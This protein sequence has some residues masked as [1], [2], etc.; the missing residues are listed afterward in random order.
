MVT[1]PPCTDVSM[2]WPPLSTCTLMMGSIF[3]LPSVPNTNKYN[4]RIT[5]VEYSLPKSFI[6]SYIKIKTVESSKKGT[7]KA[8][9]FK[10]GR[11]SV[12]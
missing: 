1:M 6:Y 11:T 4:R 3:S 2:V 7:G 10:R 5:L 8:C 9:F 12:E